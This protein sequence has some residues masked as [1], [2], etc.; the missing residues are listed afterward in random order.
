MRP[1]GYYVQRSCGLFPAPLPQEGEAIDRA[2]KVF[3]FL[4]IFFAKC[5]QDNRLVDIPL[6]RPFLK[7][8]CMGD[9]VDNVSQNYRELLTRRPSEDLDSPRSDD[10]TPTED[11]D[12]ELILD[13]PKPRYRSQISCTSTTS[14]VGTPWYAG[15]LTHEDFELVDPH[16]ARFMRHLRDLSARKAA[17]M[18]RSE[19]TEEEKHNSLQQLTLDNPPVRLE[20]L[21]LNFTFNPSS[22]VYG[23]VSVEL[24]P[25]GEEEVC[26]F[27][28][29]VF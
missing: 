3:H 22:K 6:S 1:A 10:S 25:N 28:F 2:E 18:A 14:T 19:L 8:L 16:R 27:C 12:K 26:I 7:L 4:G 20:D 9:V 5:I 11:M 24:K 15:L 29:F 21:S 13:P 23:Y 17:L